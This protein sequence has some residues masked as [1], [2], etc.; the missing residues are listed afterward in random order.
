MKIALPALVNPGLTESGHREEL[1][2]LV[3]DVIAQS[4]ADLVVLPELSVCGYP[5]LAD[6]NNDEAMLDQLS[7]P[8]DGPSGQAFRA[9]AAQS[10]CAVVYGISERP[11]ASSERFNTLVWA[12]PDGTLSSYRKVHLTPNERQHWRP[13]ELPGL[14]N[15]RDGVVGLSACNDKAFPDAYAAQRAAGAR[16]SVI[17]SA[18][19]SHPGSTQVVGDVWAEQSELFDRARAAETGM[20]VVSTNYRGSRAPGSPACF[21]DGRR[22]VDSLGRLQPPTQQYESGPVWSVDLAAE[23]AVLDYL[24]G[25]RFF[26]RPLR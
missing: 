17:A 8:I 18:W 20:V 16:L 26:G 6:A 15:T 22:V 23:A 3:S 21:C 10:G 2:K 5:E 14:I 12:D 1:T 24:H 19:A 9:L 13:G 11:S 4:G 7:E 25:T